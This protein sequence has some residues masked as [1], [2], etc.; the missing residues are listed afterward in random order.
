MVRIIH[1]PP[2]HPH[3]T[4]HTFKHPHHH[5]P[6]A[7]LGHS[8]CVFYYNAD[9]SAN[10]RGWYY[11]I[12]VFGAHSVRAQKPALRTLPISG[13][14]RSLS[15][16]RA[17]TG[18]PAAIA[19]QAPAPG[20]RPSQGVPLGGPRAPA[21]APVI[22]PVMASVHLY[23]PVSGHRRARR[24]SFNPPGSLGARPRR[25]RAPGCARGAGPCTR[26]RY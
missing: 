23:W 11:I 19:R 13:M 10:S 14:Q 2:P 8:H 1:L 3:R 24:P 26:R 15:Q 12:V 9:L 5:T 22:A 21:P 17:K 20:V 25:T 6:F 16:K 4:Q 7:G 18:Q